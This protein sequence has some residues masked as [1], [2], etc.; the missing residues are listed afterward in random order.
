MKSCRIG[1]TA[2]WGLSLLAGY[3]LVVVLPVCGGTLPVPATG[4]NVDESRVTKILYVDP[5]H[6]EATDDNKH[7]TADAPFATLAFACDAAARAKDANV[8]VKIVLAAGTYREAAEIHAPAS[9]VADTDAPLVI[10]AAEREQAVLDGADTEGWTPS[11]WK[12]DGPHWTHPWPFRRSV[13]GRPPAGLPPGATGE[14]SRRGDLLFVNGVILRQVNAAA[15]LAPGCFWGM[16]PP[17]NAGGRRGAA[18]V[19]GSA[20]GPVAVVQPPEDTELAGAIIQVGVRARGLMITGRR[21]VVVRGLLIQHAADPAD[22]GGTGERAAGFVIDRCANVL[23][24]DVLSQWNDGTGLLIAGR[25]GAPGGGDITLRRVRTL[26]NGGSGLAVFN[27]KNLLVEDSESSFNNFRGSWAGWIDPQ[28]VAG[29]KAEEVG[30]STWRRQHAVGNACRGLWWAGGNTDVT[31]EDAVVRDNAI[32]GMFLE[33]NPGPVRMRRCLV[34]GTKAPPGTTPDNTPFC[35]G[36]AVAGTP[37]LTLESNVFADNAGTQFGLTDSTGKASAPHA[38]RHIYRHNVF[39]S[40]DAD[41][42]L[43]R[44]PAADGEAKSG[45][46]LY[47]ATLDSRDNCFWNPARPEGF[48]SYVARVAGRKT[49]ALFASRLSR[50]EDWQAASQKEAGSL[51]EDPRF[52][53][54]AEGD[55]RLK[56]TSPVLEWEL[57]T[58]EAVEGQ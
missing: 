53:D 5:A 4:A 2:A 42:S 6:T 1:P 21:N 23:V 41:A 48:D 43:Y 8:G 52:V 11:T 29:V 30:G 18:T 27:V 9:G 35:A 58:E 14:S 50:L 25:D 56:K 33:D 57:P 51:W 38:A 15:D 36:L 46:S 32:T 13:S 37:D 20:A 44:A 19:G 26:H 10:E 3:L 28:G 54:P 47:Y 40:A 7:G 16:P 17:V 24:E 39:A 12:P 31:V 49:G 45:W 22:P 55:Y 34:A